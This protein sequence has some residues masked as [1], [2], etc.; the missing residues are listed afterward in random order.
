ML[1]P[2]LCIPTLVG[3][4]EWHVLFTRRTDTVADHKGQVS[5]PGGREEK[6]DGSL[7]A[8]A[9]REAE[10]EIGLHPA[11][12]RIVGRLER[13]YTITNYLITPVVGLIPWPYSFQLAASEVRRVFTIPLRW[14]ADENHY[15]IHEREVPASGLIRKMRR[16]IIFEPYEDEVLWGVS[17]EI[18]LRLL[19]KLGLSILAGAE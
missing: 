10:E 15:A 7:A 16:V 5:F 3:R 4:T 19:W 9:L 8:T 11:D 13:L 6:E 14:L 17:A 1:I 18:T 2:L 12:V